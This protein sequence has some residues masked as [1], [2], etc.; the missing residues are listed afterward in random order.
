MAL[1]RSDLPST[2]SR[3]LMPS[4]GSYWFSTLTLVRGCSSPMRR[5]CE[6][7]ASSSWAWRSRMPTSF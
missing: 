3:R 1:M 5:L 6:A 4:L 7:S 2:K